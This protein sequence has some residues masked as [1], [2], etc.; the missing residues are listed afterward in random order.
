MAPQAALSYLTRQILLILQHIFFGTAELYAVV[1]QEQSGGC[2]E[3]EM[4]WLI[5]LR[6]RMKD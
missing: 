2:R 5:S 3:W 4:A 6:Q 1:R